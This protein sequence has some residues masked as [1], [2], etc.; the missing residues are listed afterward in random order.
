MRGCREWVSVGILTVLAWAVG[1]IAF[2]DESPAVARDVAAAPEK[3]FTLRING[4]PET[5][6]WN[7]AHTPIETYVLMNI[8]EGLVG[9]DSSLKP[10]PSLAQSW[11][12]SADGRTYTFKLRSGVKWS[13]GVPLK[14]ADFVYSWKRLLSPVTAAY[15][16]SL[17]SGSSGVAAVLAHSPGVE[18]VFFMP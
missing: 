4:E 6:D 15:S 8:M 17:R 14:A 2:A 1:A 5:L 12:T 3:T 9:F 13:D 7:K 16:C 18:G 11:S 10:I